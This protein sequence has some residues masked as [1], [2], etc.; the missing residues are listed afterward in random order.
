MNKC[1]VIS[2]ASS[3]IGREIAVTL[4]RLGFKL[5]ILGRNQARLDQTQELTKTDCESLTADLS[6]DLSDEFKDSFKNF[7]T[8]NSPE[9]I[10]LVNNAGSVKRASFSETRIEDWQEALNQNLYSALRLTQVFLDLSKNIKHKQILNISST[11]GLRP[12]T[13]TSTYSAAKA[14]LCS[15]TQCLALELAP[16]K[17][18]V[19]SICP[20]LVETP[21]HDFFETQNTELRQTLDQM[22]PLGRMGQVQDIARAVAFFAEQKELWVTGVNL[23][24]DG[25]ILLKS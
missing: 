15:W 23:P 13:E 17:I 5:L 7:L 14:A 24:V 11:L 3:G 4:S 1:A 18:P 10:I 25:G 6:Q 12:I 8:S 21:I 22:Q 9:Q 16:E 20:G 19:N 2:G